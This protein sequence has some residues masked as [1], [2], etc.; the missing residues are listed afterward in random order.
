LVGVI[1][2]LPEIGKLARLG[3]LRRGLV[4]VFPIHVAQGDDV[5]GRNRVQVAATASARGD[6][7][8]VQFVVEVLS[9]QKRRGNAYRASGGKQRAGELSASKE[10]GFHNWN[11]IRW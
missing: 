9:A 3:K 7:G 2:H 6:D 5:L 4:Q 10:V 11:R 8:D 1:E